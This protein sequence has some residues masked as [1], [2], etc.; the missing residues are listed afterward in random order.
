MSQR[1]S[2]SNNRWRKIVR[3][4]LLTGAVCVALY[5]FAGKLHEHNPIDRWLFWKEGKAAAAALLLLATFTTSG[6]ALVERVRPG[7]PIRERLTLGVAGGVYLF[8]VVQVAGGLIGLFGH[9]WAIVMPL[10]LFSGGL[11]LTWPTWRRLWRR[12]ARYRFTFGVTST[13]H[14]PLALFG[15]A[16]VIGLYLSILSP[17]NAAFDSRWYHLGLGEGWMATGGIVRTPEGWFMDAVP[18]MAAVLYSWGFQL[19]GYDLFETVMVAAHIEFVLFVTT[20]AFIPMLVRYLVPRTA[21]GVSWVA[22]FLFPSVF[23]YDAGLHLGNDH[24]AAFWGVPLFLALRRTWKQLAWRDAVL[25]SMF[26]AGAIMS[27][28]Q[29]ASLVLGPAVAVIVRTAWLSFKRRDTAALKTFGVA[30]ACSVLFTSPLWAKNLIFYG[31]PFF[32]A[33]HNHLALRP[34][35]EG[36]S[37]LMEINWKVFVHRPEGPLSDQLQESFDMGFK[38]SFTTHARKGFHGAM[39][40]FGS[41]F[42]LSLFWLPLLPRAKRTWALAFCAQFGVFFWFF[43]SHVERYLQILIPW[44]AVVVAAAVILAW[45]QG[46]LTRLPLA[47]LVMIQVIWGGDALFLRAHAMLRDTPIIESARLIESGYKKDYKR[48]T[49]VTGFQPIGQSLPD[50]S[51]LIL[52]DYNSRLG[53]KHRVIVDKARYQGLIRYGLMS[54]ARQVYDLYKSLGV[55]HVVFRNKSTNYDSVAGDIRFF[56]YTAGHLKKRRT[57]GSFAVA[58][59]PLTPPPANTGSG[60]VAYAGCGRTFRRGLHRLENMD[61]QDRSA[62]NRAGFAPLPKDQEGLLEALKQAQFL[63]VGTRCKGG[64]PWPPKHF[65]LVGKRRTE[66][67]W[68]RPWKARR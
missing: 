58:P 33:L 48:R 63:V 43:F 65:K 67:L 29:A 10:A 47:A 54:S 57:F 42:T 55:T 11:Y 38:F 68:A 61:V 66:E 31:D 26:A 13:W 5:Y 32:P 59:L 22:L 17:K 30:F 44:M 7:L 16:G 3:T 64:V 19:P 24:I 12:R 52:H 56:D 4:V 45:R 23:I 18:N 27:K 34:W 21:V 53:L 50:G 25:L 62:Q 15:L 36:L 9:A 14:A 49:S 37:E 41:L 39:P 8:Y 2:G 1:V 6:L 51:V 46:W 35:S 60:I 40:Y 20:L 28:Y